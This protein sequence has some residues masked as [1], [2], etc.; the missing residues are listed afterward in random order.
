[1]SNVSPEIR[2]FLQSVM[3]DAQTAAQVSAEW[4]SLPAPAQYKAK[5]RNAMAAPQGAAAQHLN[6][7]SNMLQQAAGTMMQ[8]LSEGWGIPLTSVEPA[9]DKAS[10]AKWF[11][12][13]N[14]EY[15]AGL[16]AGTQRAIEVFQ[17]VRQQ[18]GLVVNLQ[19]FAE[20]VAQNKGQSNIFRFIE[21]V[22]ASYLDAGDVFALFLE[23][24]DA[25]RRPGHTHIFIEYCAAF[26]HKDPR[27]DSIQWE[28]WNGV[29]NVIHEIVSTAQRTHH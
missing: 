7:P 25:E 8:L 29:S 11:L 4:L 1:M 2:E 18:A 6:F 20:Q 24:I 15:P 10:T 3:A 12:K 21:A 5:I 23:Y 9:M 26:W 28:D 14:P 16:P 27:P 17:G 19:C 22:P 13:A